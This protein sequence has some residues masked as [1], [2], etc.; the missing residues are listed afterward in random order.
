MEKD[1]ARDSEKDLGL[2]MEMEMG[3]TSFRRNSTHIHHR[4]NRILRTVLSYTA[5]YTSVLISKRNRLGNSRFN[6]LF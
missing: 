4:T 3:M 1:W 6:N 2:V 5:L